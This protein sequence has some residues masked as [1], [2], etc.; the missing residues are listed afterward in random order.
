MR[1]GTDL[2]IAGAL[3]KRTPVFHERDV[4]VFTAVGNHFFPLKI[5]YLFEYFDEK[6]NLSVFIE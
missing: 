5:V 2:K 1:A 6:Q 4:Q 3:R